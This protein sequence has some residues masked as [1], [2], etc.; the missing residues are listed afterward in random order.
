[1]VKHL[2]VVI[3]G[4]SEKEAWLHWRAYDG[5]GNASVYGIYSEGGGGA[6]A[7][8]GAWGLDPFDSFKSVIADPSVH[9]VE[10]L[11]PM[12]GR[13]DAALAA[14][15]AGKHVLM[16][17]PFAAGSEQAGRLAGAARKG[18]PVLMC[19]ENWMFYPPMQKIFKLVKKKSIGRVTGLRMR[20][21]LA[22]LGGWD[23]DLNPHY[24]SAENA[25]PGAEPDYPAILFRESYEKLS[26]ALRLFG[27]IQEIHS[28]SPGT[29]DG[30][31]AA[32]LAWKHKAH[33]TYGVLEAALA[34]DMKIRSA[35]DPRDDTMELTGSAGI[36]WLKH[37]ASQ[38]RQE[39]AV[40]AIRGENRFAYGNIED[41]WLSGYMF[42]ACHFADC[43]EHRRT[44]AIDPWHSAAAT[45]AAQAAARSAETGQRVGL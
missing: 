3:C 24:K 13:V 45:A 37:A 22:G 10:L 6:D 31:G 21:V 34:P 40:H 26:L 17:T 19:Y 5:V 8:A 39:P 32:V 27:P 18:G 36:I 12:P 2:N 9:V 38:M 4:G 15:D 16:G 30:R 28:I 29:L 20:A 44:P 33:G 43:V 11:D 1:V 14:L 25:V 23:R 41:D 7:R 35:Y 42:C